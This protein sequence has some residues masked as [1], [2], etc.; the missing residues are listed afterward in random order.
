VVLSRTGMIEKF[1]KLINSKNDN[2]EEINDILP[3]IF[4]NFNLILKRGSNI[5]QKIFYKNFTNSLENEIAFK[6]IY[7]LIQ[8]KI[9]NL[10]SY[11]TYIIRLN[12]LKIK[13][14]LRF[15][16]LKTNFERNLDSRV[17][18]F[19][20][21]LCENHNSLL[22]N[23]LGYQF[24]FR[25][26][27]N[28]ISI[29][30]QYLQQLYHNKEGYTFSAVMKCLDCLVEFIQG[31]CLENQ[32]VLMNS[33]LISTISEILDSFISEEECDKEEQKTKLTVEKSIMT[34]KVI[35]D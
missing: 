33:K 34:Y 28:L 10:I 9:S 15:K 20:Q 21:L 6:Y 4:D 3:Y 12:K 25:K 14:K 31:P 27:Y 22:Q 13:K 19:L 5:I 18:R 35:K 32:N 17:L 8:E 24:N 26:S 23:Y 11:K 16:F 30:N 1:L 29:T 7:Q 2:Q